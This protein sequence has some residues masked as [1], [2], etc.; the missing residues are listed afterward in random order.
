LIHFDTFRETLL[1]LKA[2]ISTSFVLEFHTKQ[3]DIAS[4]ELLHYLVASFKAMCDK[5]S[6]NRNQF[7]LASHKALYFNCCKEQSA[8]QLTLRQLNSR[9]SLRRF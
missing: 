2:W 7:A 1:V 8:L 9:W 6:E 5:I 3:C 4:I